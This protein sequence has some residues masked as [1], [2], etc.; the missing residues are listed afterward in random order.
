MID[1]NPETPPDSPLTLHDVVESPFYNDLSTPDLGEGDAA[2]AFALPT[3]SG[4]IVRLEDFRGKRP[5]ALVFGSY[6]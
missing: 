4:G 5:V 2:Y 6:T 1:E 3:P